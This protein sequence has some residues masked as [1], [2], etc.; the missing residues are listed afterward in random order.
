MS[1]RLPG[2]QNLY[3]TMF[4]TLGVYNIRYLRNRFL[5]PSATLLAQLVI[6]KGNTHFLLML[7]KITVALVFYLPPVFCDRTD[8]NAIN[9]QK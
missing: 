8:R 9:H 5:I 6:I 1:F 3:K 2:D 7:W 4:T